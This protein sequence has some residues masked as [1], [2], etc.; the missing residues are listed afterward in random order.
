MSLK[1][2]TLNFDTDDYNSMVLYSILKEA[3]RGYRMRILADVVLMELDEYSNLLKYG[4]D[5]DSMAR[6]LMMISDNYRSSSAEYF[7]RND[8][9]SP[10]EPSRWNH[11]QKESSKRIHDQTDSIETSSKANT[12]PVN[13]GDGAKLTE[14]SFLNKNPDVVSQHSHNT[15][16]TS[17][18]NREKFLLS[19]SKWIKE[20]INEAITY[21]K[22]SIPIPQFM[23]YEKVIKM[24][25]DD[26]DRYEETV[27]SP[28]LIVTGIVPLP[29]QN[30]SF[31]SWLTQQLH[32]K[33][34]FEE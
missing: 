19:H 32:N 10:K 24:L 13:T 14:E 8:P 12:I 18:S 30:M 25:D 31:E 23:E 17:T 7:R 26:E 21:F 16:M 28:G 33:N 22:D 34:I 9:I 3:K 27:V 5:P 15:K 29:S 11:L 2:I 6:I 1:R 4:N 20:M